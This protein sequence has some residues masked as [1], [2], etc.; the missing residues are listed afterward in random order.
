[1]PA[2]CQ[3]NALTLVLKKPLEKL[4]LKKIKIPLNSDRAKSKPSNI[5]RRQI[6]LSRSKVSWRSAIAISS[7]STQVW[8]VGL[9]TKQFR[10]KGVYLFSTNIPI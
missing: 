2:K 8:G 5:K 4:N 6:A 3:Q 1:M 10:V 7:N 9:L